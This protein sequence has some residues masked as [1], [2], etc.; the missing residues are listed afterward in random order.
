VPW[1]SRA[2]TQLES[3]EWRNWH[4]LRRRLWFGCLV[5]VQLWSWDWSPFVDVARN[6][7]CSRPP[8]S[9]G[10]Y[11]QPWQKG[12]PTA[13]SGNNCPGLWSRLVLRA[14]TTPGL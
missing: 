7:R 2:A 5:P 10:S 12:V 1:R 6:A 8:F 11:Y 14:E 4:W 3:E 9:P 13:S